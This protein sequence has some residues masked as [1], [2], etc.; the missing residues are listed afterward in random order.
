MSSKMLALLAVFVLVSQV[1]CLNVPPADECDPADSNTCPEGYLCVE[2]EE[3]FP[4]P[5]HKK[6]CHRNKKCENRAT[7]QLLDNH[8][9][10]HQTTLGAC[11]CTSAAEDLHDTHSLTVPFRTTSYVL[12]ENTL[13]LMLTTQIH[14]VADAKTR[15]ECCLAHAMIIHQLG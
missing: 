9:I 12:N 1:M 10:N 3:C 14:C 8:F 11:L 6:I 7:T 15:T 4:N 13:F 5:P 2:I